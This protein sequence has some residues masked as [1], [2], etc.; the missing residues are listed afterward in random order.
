MRVIIG[1]AQ[2]DTTST[3]YT[4]WIW[5]FLVSLFCDTKPHTHFSWDFHIVFS[6]K[7]TLFKKKK[8]V[9]NEILYSP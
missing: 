2:T 1:E 7:I 8:R 5:E 9:E 4:F 3:S 6:T